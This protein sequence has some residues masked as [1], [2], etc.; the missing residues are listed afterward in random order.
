M[1]GV[2]ELGTSSFL[3]GFRSDAFAEYLRCQLN[4]ATRHAIREDYRAAGG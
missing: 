2:T 1:V 4:P 3:A